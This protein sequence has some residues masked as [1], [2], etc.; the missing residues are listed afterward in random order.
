MI[1]LDMNGLPTVNLSGF[2][3][4]K[5][6]L[7]EENRIA[8]KFYCDING[9]VVC[10]QAGQA[11]EAYFY[12]EYNRII[13]VTFL[14]QDGEPAAI[15]DGYGILKKTYYRD[16]NEKT[17]MYF[18]ASGNPV[19]LNKGQYG[20][21]RVGEISLYL[22]KNGQ[23]KLCIDNLLN[24]YPVMVVVIGIV[25]CILF[26]IVPQ[27][28]KVVI[29]L[30]YMLFIFYETLMFREIGNIRANLVLFSYANTFLRSW[31]I[32]VDVINNVWL[33]IPFGTGLYA[34]FRKK[35][36]WITALVLSGV[37]ESIQY[38]TGLGIAEL[39]DLFGNTLGGVIGVAAGVAIF[40]VL[41]KWRN[42]SKERMS[43]SV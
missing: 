27:K 37:I 22:N 42:M 29:F 8:Q 14:N 24:A 25:L 41:G 17:N 38:F 43:D 15:K 33:F 5:R 7:D 28:L 20:I 11:G 3:Q 4:E 13:Q 18:D 12:D 21:Q 30:F 35:K 9:K 39:D 23:V 36:V 34:I 6:I 16:G 2:V 1:Y 32:R 26:C 31:K 40:Y 10:L 19:P